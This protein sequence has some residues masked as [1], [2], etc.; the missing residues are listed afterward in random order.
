LL[1]DPLPDGPAKG[2][3]VNL[4]P[5]LD[6]YYGYRGWDKDGKPLPARL[7]ELGLEW[8]AKDID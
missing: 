7:Q 8:L 2:H 1:N 3:V 4:E 5:L 6:A